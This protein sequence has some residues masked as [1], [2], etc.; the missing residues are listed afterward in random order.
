MQST[1]CPVHS[2]N[3][4]ILHFYWWLVS[5]KKR[6]TSS[7]LLRELRRCVFVWFYRSFSCHSV[8][9]LQMTRFFASVSF[10]KPFGKYHVC[11]L[12]TEKYLCIAYPQF[13]SHP[14]RQAVK[15]SDTR[16]ARVRN[17][18]LRLTTNQIVCVGFNSEI[19]LTT[20]STLKLVARFCSAF[21]V[22]LILGYL[23]LFWE[24]LH[25]CDLEE[26]EKKHQNQNRISDHTQCGSLKPTTSKLVLV[27]SSS[28]LFLFL[29]LLL[30]SDIYDCSI[31][32]AIDCV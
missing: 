27:Y 16:C 6:E 22:R 4:H 21:V 26:E 25:F 30:L 19:E 5:W 2:I 18:R 9:L 10:S 11:I 13:A 14:K 23:G 17:T 7:L 31:W 8:T 1:I 20:F 24:L 32:F 15:R 28:P 3:R 29:L 12:Y